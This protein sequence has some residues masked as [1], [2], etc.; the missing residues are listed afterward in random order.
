M[1]KGRK[2][3]QS[4]FTKAATYDTATGKKKIKGKEKEKEKEKE[5]DGES[6]PPRAKTP[7][8][9]LKKKDTTLQKV[10]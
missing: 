7:V 1:S 6:D 2:K 4:K 8:N 5:K 9:S 3:L 10:N